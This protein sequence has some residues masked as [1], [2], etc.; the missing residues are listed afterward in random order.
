MS[1]QAAK[2]HCFSFCIHENNAFSGTNGIQLNILLP[3][4]FKVDSQSEYWMTG[5]SHI[6][7]FNHVV[8]KGHLAHDKTPQS[9]E[10]WSGK[11]GAAIG[12]NNIHS[13]MNVVSLLY[14]D[15][16]QD[17]TENTLKFI[18]KHWQETATDNNKGKLRNS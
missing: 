14:R 18:V 2:H 13:G 12:I 4:L 7:G 10:A 8:M 1:E 11:N 3:S 17:S 5:Q 16:L 9:S 6:R 15:V